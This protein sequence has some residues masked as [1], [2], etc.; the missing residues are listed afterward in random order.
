MLMLPFQLFVTILLKVHYKPGNTAV[1]H[2]IFDKSKYSLRIYCSVSRN[3]KRKY[4]VKAIVM[5]KICLN[6]YDDITIARIYLVIIPFTIN[7]LYENAI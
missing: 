4:E 5:R 1:W 7:S 6:Y 2:F 3:R